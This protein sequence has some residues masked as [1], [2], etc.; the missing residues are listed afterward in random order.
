MILKRRKD[1]PDLPRGKSSGV[2]QKI[3]ELDRNIGHKSVLY[4]CELFMDRYE[5]VNL[6]DQ[7]IRDMEGIGDTSAE[8]V[9]GIYQLFA[10]AFSVDGDATL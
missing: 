6:V 4:I 2:K 1:E 5:P 8:G 9:N 3:T 10:A 7:A